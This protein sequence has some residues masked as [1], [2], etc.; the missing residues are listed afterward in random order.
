MAID[1]FQAVA[2]TIARSRIATVLSNA[3]AVLNVA[4]SRS[5]CWR[6]I[7]R[8]G[9]AGTHADGITKLRLTGT[10]LL[11]ATITQQVLTLKVPSWLRPAFSPVLTVDVMM[12]SIA[13]VL[14]APA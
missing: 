6:Q 3:A 11:A 5:W 13:L 10:A 12:L 7:V 2:N 14:A 1:D 8:L 4:L 9:T